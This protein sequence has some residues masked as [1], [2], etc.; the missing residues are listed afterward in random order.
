MTDVL[1][2]AG[3]TNAQLKLEINGILNIINFVTAVSMCFAIDKFGRRPLFL[4]ATGGML[5]SFVIWTIC[6][7]EFVKTQIAAAGYAEIAFIFIYYVFY[8][9]A[10]SGLL[11]GYAVEV[12]PYKLR[13]KVCYPAPPPSLSLS[14][15]QIYKETHTNNPLFQG[16]TLMF[17]AVDLALFFNSYVNP[18]ALSKLGWKYY[19]VYDV[20]LAVELLV[21]Y[22]FYIETRNTPLEE[23]VKYFDGENALLGGDVAT[24][25]ARELL[26]EEFGN[27]RK[28]M[29]EKSV[30]VE[31]RE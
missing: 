28:V 22:L 10:W 1:T 31:H 9:C 25:K 18:I 12:L 20:W 29:D 11:V 2:Q 19:I 24:T 17:L 3:V 21:V 27:D 7:A 8:N 13:A 30:G 14:I 26:V 23:I 15:H 6:A 4:L 5:G 16:L